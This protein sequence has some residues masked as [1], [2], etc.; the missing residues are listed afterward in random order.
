MR[1]TF[2]TPY[3]LQVKMSDHLH[4]LKLQIFKSFLEIMIIIR[5]IKNLLRTYFKLRH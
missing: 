2:Q 5:H 3:V 1:Y 4:L